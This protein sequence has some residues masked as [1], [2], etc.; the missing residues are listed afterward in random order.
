[1]RI[2]AKADYALR[3]MIVLA[4]R[5]ARG[6]EPVK[7]DEIA[8]AGEIPPKFL[9]TILVQLRRHG[10]LTS[11]RGADGGYR[12]A[13]PP[14]EVSVADVLR[15]VDGPLAQVLGRAPE[16]LDYPR[17]VAALGRVWREAAEAVGEVLEGATLDRLARGA[18]VPDFQI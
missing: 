12:L 1:V 10:L 2:S 9:E 17:D 16:D 11:K 14:E 5:H 7:V 6:R 4:D 8:R 13:R 15:T 18:A 3:A